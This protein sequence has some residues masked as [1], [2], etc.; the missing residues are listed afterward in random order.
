ML[1]GRNGF[2]AGSPQLSGIAAG[3]PVPTN[4]WWSLLV[5][6]NHVNNLFNYPLALATANEGLIVSNIV[7]VS[8]PNGSSQPNND[9]DNP[10]IVRP[11]VVGVSGLN[12]GQATV[13]DH[14]DWTVSMNWQSGSNNFTATAGI[15]M[16]F[17]YFTQEHN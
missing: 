3:K 1:P 16:P 14:S 12:A 15:A 4:D 17:L 5:K 9:Y 11:I 2:P 10:N 13:S 8:T 6:E 7:P